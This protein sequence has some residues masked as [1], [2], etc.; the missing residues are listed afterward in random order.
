M[1]AINLILLGAP[2]SG[3]GTLAKMICAEYGLP[4]LS[5]GDMLR[6]SVKDGTELGERVK[7][8][9]NEGKLVPDDIVIDVLRQR[10][11]EKDCE[12]GFIMDGFPRTGKQAEELEE[13]LGEREMSIDA[14]IYLEVPEEVLISRLSGRR[15]CVSCG[16]IYHIDNMPSKRDGICDTCSSRLYQREDDKRETIEV[17]LKAYEEKTAGLIDFYADKNL[18]KFIKGDSGPEAVFE[19]IKCIIESLEFSRVK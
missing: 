6:K 7:H 12:C 18:L 2:G 11:S 19:E 9:M 10:L 16:D 1:G 5:T 17:R 4:H 14:V 13:I 15:Q 8:Y 3:K